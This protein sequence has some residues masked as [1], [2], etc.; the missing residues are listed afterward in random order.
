M[1]F[2]FVQNDQ[3][4][5]LLND[6]DLTSFKK[7][8]IVT[9]DISLHFLV[10][11]CSS[12][13]ILSIQENNIFTNFFSTGSDVN[14]CSGKPWIAIDKLKT[15]W[16]FDLSNKKKKKEG[17]VLLYGC[18]S[19]TYEAPGEKAQ[20]ELHKNAVCCFELILKAAP[21]KKLQLYGHLSPISQTAIAV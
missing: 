11:F 13:S 19:W 20:W 2:R 9:E 1:P 18:T 17:S 12:I 6:S 15:I 8:W 14:I 4:F 5:L 7:N 10:Y 16:K 21:F 3:T